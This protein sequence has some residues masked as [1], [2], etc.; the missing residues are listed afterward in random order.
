M[1]KLLL[2][3]LLSAAVMGFAQTPPDQATQ[4]QQMARQKQE[5]AMKKQEE[6]RKKL[7]AARIA[8]ITERLNLTPEQAEKFWPVYNEYAE[9][10]RAL[11]REFLQTKKK[12]D[13]N[14]LTEEQSRQ[15]MQKRLEM[16]EKQLKLEKKYSDRLMQVINTR[17]M[18]ALK[19]AE[20]DFRAMLIRR[21]EMRKRQQ[22]QR[23]RMMMERERKMQQGN[24]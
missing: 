12:M 3:W 5:Q 10:R 2:G 13:V 6:A 16:K 21:L 22:M 1:K 19:K 17:Q 20:D 15:L 8:L 24:N 18:M 11:Q 14:N 7:E 4:N 23:Q 9:Q